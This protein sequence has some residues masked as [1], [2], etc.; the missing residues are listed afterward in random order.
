MHTKDSTENDWKNLLTRQSVAVRDID[1]FQD[2]PRLYFS[3]E[4]VARF[5]FIKLSEFNEPFALIKA[6]HST[7]H[8][9]TLNADDLSGLQPLI[10]L[11]RKA[12]VVLTCNLWSAVCL[13]NGACGKVI[14]L[15]YK[16][17]QSPPELPVAIIV[18][19]EHYIG[20]SISD[21]VP[22]CVPICPITATFQECDYIHEHQQLPLRLSWAFTIHKAEGLTLPTAWI[23][24]GKQKE[25]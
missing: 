15:V 13:V 11:A 8:A 21:S 23:D 5:N 19:F 9:K 18:Q 24:L 3:N 4:D 25:S 2:C 7:Q 17:G 1:D 16:L 14:D 22:C 12:H 10:F 6:V 20:P